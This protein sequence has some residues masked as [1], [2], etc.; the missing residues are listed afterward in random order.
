MRRTAH[1]A[2]SRVPDLPNIGRLS[3]SFCELH[4]CPTYYGRDDDGFGDI[5]LG[6]QFGHSSLSLTETVTEMQVGGVLGSRDWTM[7]FGA[8]PQTIEPRHLMVSDSGCVSTK[9]PQ[10]SES[11]F[12]TT[13]S[14]SMQPEARD[15]AQLGGETR[16]I[17]KQAKASRVHWPVLGTTLNPDL[18]PLPAWSVPVT[19]RGDNHLTGCRNLGLPLRACH[20]RATPRSR[21]LTCWC[22]QQISRLAIGE[23]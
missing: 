16:Q 19:C 17:W 8:I 6:P 4:R 7:F 23:D 21:N 11:K 5:L 14:A 3:L 15:E 13:G 1:C 2:I 9:R 10:A 12:P 18:P 22:Q 20:R